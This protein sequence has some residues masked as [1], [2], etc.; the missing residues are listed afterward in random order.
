MGVILLKLTGTIFKYDPFP[1][2]NRGS[3]EGLERIPNPTVKIL[4]V[5]IELR[6]E[7]ASPRNH[8]RNDA[9]YCSSFLFPPTILKNTPWNPYTIVDKWRY[10]FFGAP[11]E[12][13]E[14]TTWV[15][16]ALGTPIHGVNTPCPTSNWIFL[17]RSPL[18]KSTPRLFA[19]MAHRSPTEF[20]TCR[21]ASSTTSCRILVLG[22]G[23]LPVG[24][25]FLH[26]LDHVFL[27]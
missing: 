3:H 14:N 8:Y 24:S 10:I 5:T 19:A 2:Y 12:M 11:I 18:S 27:R 25:D 21:A 15:T 16:G 7:G 6:G 1:V 20:A 26:S 22:L 17:G 23:D 13:S 4:V 9:V